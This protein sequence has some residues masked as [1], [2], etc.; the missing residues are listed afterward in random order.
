M[1]DL[2]EMF[3]MADLFAMADASVRVVCDEDW[4]RGMG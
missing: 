1:F 4:K 2:F 3:D